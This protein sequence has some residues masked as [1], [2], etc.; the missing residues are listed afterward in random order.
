MRPMRRRRRCAMAGCTPMG[1]LDIDGFLFLSDRKKD[2]IIRGG[3][4]I[5][6]R[7]VEELAFP[8]AELTTASPWR[9]TCPCPT[10][11]E[12]ARTTQ[13]LGYGAPYEWAH[14]VHVPFRPLS[15]PLAARRIALRPA[16]ARTSALRHKRALRDASDG[17]G[18]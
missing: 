11:S 16:Q 3:E 10:Y 1:Y 14:Y 5:S 17:E 12:S 4:N 7:E 6:P 8:I 15:K 9:T 2:L 18:V 13:A